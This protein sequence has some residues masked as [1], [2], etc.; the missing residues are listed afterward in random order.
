M[1]LNKTIVKKV[2]EKTALEPALG[3][4]IV[5][6]LEYESEVHGWFKADYNSFLEK[7]CKEGD[8]DENS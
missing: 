5:D 7:T 6:V 4:F 1:A 2:R 8:C 3:N